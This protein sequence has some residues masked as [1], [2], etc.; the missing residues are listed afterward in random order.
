MKMKMV[1]H[2][3]GRTYS[4]EESIDL[5]EDQKEAVID[6]I[7]D[8]IDT[9]VKFKMNTEDGVVVFGPEAIKNW[10]VEFVVTKETL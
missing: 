6:E 8:S 5:S 9:L 1:V 2:V 7:F 4:T 3:N 10:V